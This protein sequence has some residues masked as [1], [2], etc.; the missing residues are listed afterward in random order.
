LLTARKH[1]RLGGYELEATR[2]WAAKVAAC[3]AF[4]FVMPEYNQAWLRRW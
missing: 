4:V 2:A 3:D 1:P